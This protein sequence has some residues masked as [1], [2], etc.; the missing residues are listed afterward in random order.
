MMTPQSIYLFYIILVFCG[1]QEETPQEQPAPIWKKINSCGPN[2][3]YLYL[4]Y[5]S[6]DIT[7]EMISSEVRINKNGISLYDLALISERHGIPSRIIKT[8]KMLVGELE[9]PFIAHFAYGNV[10][11]PSGHYVFVSEVNNDMVTYIDG[12]TG[13]EI[14]IPIEN[15]KHYW[16]GYAM[17]RS[18]RN[19]LLTGILT[20]CLVLNFIILYTLITRYRK[21]PLI[22]ASFLFF[23]NPIFA[24]PTY[25]DDTSVASYIE[26]VSDDIPDHELVRTSRMGA[27]NCLY[28]YLKYSGSD[29]TWR[30][31]Y[32]LTSPKEGA[33]LLAIMRISSLLGH[34]LKGKRISPSELFHRGPTI[35]YLEGGAKSEG[36]FVITFSHGDGFIWALN[37]NSATMRQFTEDEFRQI[38]TGI[39]V[40]ESSSAYHNQRLLYDSFA[41]LVAGIVLFF[42][43]SSVVHRK[44]AN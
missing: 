27:V 6:C 3:L 14:T 40:V 25:A 22:V 33:S 30:N 1:L 24:I 11:S 21:K 12:T 18:E 20:L 41:G 34:P 4:T 5:Y 13:T 28:I 31:I 38:W 15:F 10:S 23:L 29:V 36:S 9:T 32:D 44:I 16:S 26:S 43:I 8:D 7:H 19:S 17:I 39:A 42:S 35:C 2:V 37:G